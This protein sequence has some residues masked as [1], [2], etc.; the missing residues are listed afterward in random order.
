MSLI[1]IFLAAATILF[2]VAS[3]GM[4]STIERDDQ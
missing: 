4:S 3:I 2:N 1:L